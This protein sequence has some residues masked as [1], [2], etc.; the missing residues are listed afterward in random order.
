MPKTV[1][2]TGKLWVK[3]GD[4]LIIRAGSSGAKG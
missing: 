2:E 4:F 1:T 3:S